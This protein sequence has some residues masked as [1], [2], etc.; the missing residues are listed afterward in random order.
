MEPVLPAWATALRDRY[1][2]GESSV[3]LLH[4]N[5]RDVQPW[6]DADGTIRFVS[7]REFLTRFLGRNK[8]LLV[9]YNVSEGIEFY[10]LDAD[11]DVIADIDADIVRAATRV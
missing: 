9:Y 7:L 4:G 2:S 8:D 5:V 1:L 10:D 11:G 3:F 6:P